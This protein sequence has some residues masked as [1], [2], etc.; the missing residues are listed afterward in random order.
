MIETKKSYDDSHGLEEDA[1]PRVITL[2]DVRAKADIAGDIGPVARAEW[3]LERIAF[4]RYA[5]TA[6]QIV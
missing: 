2:L 4:K 5:F 3:C 1:E 6:A